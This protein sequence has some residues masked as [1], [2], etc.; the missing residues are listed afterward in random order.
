MHTSH[1]GQAGDTISRQRSGRLRSES[2][3]TA[4]YPGAVDARLGRDPTAVLATVANEITQLR[5]IAARCPHSS[6]RDA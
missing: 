5:Q 4:T 2:H 1:R 6:D 3:G